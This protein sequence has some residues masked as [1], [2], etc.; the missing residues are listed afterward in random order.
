VLEVSPLL[1]GGMAPG[2][3]A[4]AV[5]D[6]RRQAL[7]EKWAARHGLDIAQR[8]AD[9]EDLA[10]AARRYITPENTEKTYATA[11]R[12]WE[13][14]CAACELPELE[15]SRGQLVAFVLWMIN[16]GRQK[17]GP[18]GVL[19]YAPN[20]AETYLS[21]AVVELRRRGVEVSPYAH[22]EAR[23]VLDGLKVKLLKAKERRGR[24]KANPAH[25]EG[26]FAIAESCPDTLEGLR[27]KALVFTSLH[28]AARASEPA[29]L[30]S[31]DVL[32]RPQ[33]LEIDVLTGKTAYSIRN[34]KI[35]YDRANPEI[36]PVL[37]YT[38]YR[39]RLVEEHGERHA[40]PDD[41]AFHWIDRHGNVRHTYDDEGNPVYGLTPAGVTRAIT[42]IS[43]RAG[44]KAAWTGHSLRI[45]LA[46]IARRNGRD[47]VA[48]ADQ[49]G[50][51][52][53][54]REMLGYMQRDN[55]WTDNASAGLIRRP[56]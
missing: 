41:P 15:G 53:H 13:R 30:L 1:L 24:G 17:P 21:G 38:A 40:Q 4:A 33:G 23:T 29:G 50:W 22:G 20:S 47:A 52:R 37:S 44:I 16:E 56:A 27:D 26:L 14:F 31:G 9:A 36:C 12:V 25:E 19:G 18:G 49:G 42:R 5:A 28:Y 51:A 6:A 7:M 45:A 11:W 3:A 10:D 43:R 54:S 48:I 46:S 34:A 8:L 32:L 55:G 35:G 39:E 2:S